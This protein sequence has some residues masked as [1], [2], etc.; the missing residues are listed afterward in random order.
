M[1]VIDEM[2]EGRRELNDALREEFMP[3]DSRL[4]F[5]K[6]STTAR[7]FEIVLTFY[8]GWFLK[9]NEFRQETRVELA[10]NEVFEKEQLRTATHI[11]IN[12][13][14]YVIAQGET[15]EPQGTK[16]YWYFFCNLF[17]NKAQF[18]PIY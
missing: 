4:E 2:I 3:P 6:P 12:D 8:Y 15:I 17:P 14:V 16:P 10:T 18:S 5:L 1:S 13:D 9:Y 7:E 11:K